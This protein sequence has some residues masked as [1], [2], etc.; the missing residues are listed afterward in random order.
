MKV[1]K[2]MN[3]VRATMIAAALSAGLAG[4]PTTPGSAGSDSLAADTADGTWCGSSVA[5][6]PVYIDVTYAADG[7]PVDP[8]DCTVTSGT[9]VTWR[10]PNGEPVM[11]EIRFKSTAPLERGE[12]SL[13]PSAETGGRYK[14]MR[15]ISG[16]RGRYDYGI[17]AN[18]KELD[19]AIIIR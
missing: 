11:F 13:L 16:P 10:G 5:T 2:V 3:A 14:V 6:G 18:D 19:P 12:P 15:K 4:C 7:T 1:M 17:K 9:D 8:G